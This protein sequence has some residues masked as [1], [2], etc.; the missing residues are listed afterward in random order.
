MVTQKNSSRDNIKTPKFSKGQFIWLAEIL[1][2]AIR[3]G[4]SVGHLVT[5]ITDDELPLTNAAY[6]PETFTRAVR[7]F[8]MAK[9]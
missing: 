7:Q 1:G 3:D 5:R 6:C 2:S 4:E 9:S 8:A